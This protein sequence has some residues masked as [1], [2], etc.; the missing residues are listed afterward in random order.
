MNSINNVIISKANIKSLRYLIALFLFV[1][2][3]SL[4]IGT[5]ADDNAPS[6]KNALNKLGMAK[7]I[8]RYLLVC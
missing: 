3:L 8:K 7:A 4:K 5:N 2:N 6:A 1:T